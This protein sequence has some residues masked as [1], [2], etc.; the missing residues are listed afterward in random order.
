MVTWCLKL[1]KKKQILDK[2]C[3]VFTI[4]LSS[5]ESY[6]LVVWLPIYGCSIT[7]VIVSL[8]EIME[9]GV[10]SDSQVTSMQVQCIS[11]HF[12]LEKGWVEFGPVNFL[13]HEIV[14]QTFALLLLKLLSFQE[15]EMPIIVIVI[16][17]FTGIYQ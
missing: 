12:L 5:V 6:L 8:L 7:M 2:F 9:G 3:N 10:I 11:P 15:G 17:N 14:D 16:Y 13:V 4:K 1:R